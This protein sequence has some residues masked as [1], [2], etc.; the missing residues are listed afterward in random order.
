[1]IDLRGGGGR[2]PRWACLFRDG[3]LRSTMGIQ[4]QGWRVVG[5]H[6]QI[7]G[8]AG[9]TPTAGPPGVKVASMAA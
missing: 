9:K 1:M 6:E 7:H 8:G 4:T 2:A 3:A 5:G